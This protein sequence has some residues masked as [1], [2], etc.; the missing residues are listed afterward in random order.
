MAICERAVPFASDAIATYKG[1]HDTIVDHCSASWS[2]DETLS[3]T[4]AK[5]VT[6]QWCFITES[7][8]LS[9]CVEKLPKCSISAELVCLGV[10]LG[11]ILAM[12][13]T[14][15]LEIEALI[16]ILLTMLRAGAPN[17]AVKWEI[18]DER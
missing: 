16:L 17:Y 3:A 13:A 6:I 5:N 14:R 11:G 2:V 7:L 4:Y 15:R 8:N 10:F 1:S 18:S 12:L 9:R